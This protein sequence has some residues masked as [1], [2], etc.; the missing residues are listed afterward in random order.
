[1]RQSLWFTLRRSKRF[2]QQER[3]E[4]EAAARHRASTM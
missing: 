4:R 2:R 3:R 1:M